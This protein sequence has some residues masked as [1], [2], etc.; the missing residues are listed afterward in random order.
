MKFE[1]R[2]SLFMIV[3]LAALP[4]VIAAQDNRQQLPLPTPIELSEE[5][6]PL[7]PTRQDPLPTL[8]IQP[9]R[10]PTPEVI[11]YPTDDGIHLATPATE[12]LIEYPTDPC[13]LNPTD[14]PG[15]ELEQI[16]CPPTETPTATYV[17]I[18]VTPSASIVNGLWVLDPNG[19]GFRSSGQ[20]QL[21]GGDNGGMGGEYQP[22]DLPKIPVCMTGDR[23]WLKVDA[24]GPYPLVVPSIYS[25][26]EMSREL[27]ESN[28]ET[29]GSVNVNISRQ[30]HVISPSEIEYSYI[31]Q[32]KGGCTTTSTVRYKL[33]EANNLVCSGVVM[34][35]NFTAV[36]TQMPTAKPGETPLP[37]VT[38]VPPIQTGEYTVQLPPVDAS[39]TADQLPQSD[40]VDV[41]YDNNQ[42]MFITFGGG[43][44]TL[45]WNGS[46][47][48]EYHKGQFMVS[49]NTYPGGASLSRIKQGCFM[50][51]QLA[52]EGAPTATPV[53]VEPT[54]EAVTDPAS[55]A[56]S[57]F[58]V[59]WDAP[60]YICAEENKS[61]LPDLST[62]VLTAKADG[63]FTFSVD[64]I[65]YTLTNQDGI[66]GF[67]QMNTDGSMTMINM[68]GF[69][70]GI[71]SGSFSAIGT[72]GKSCTSLLT[73]TP[74][75]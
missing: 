47:D 59:T 2:L 24:S 62:A 21:D 65:D 48:Y 72:G 45:F 19:S 3:V 58:S 39:C 12:E 4:L 27:L 35:P 54:S 74:Q 31:R 61:M 66:Y 56:G 55:I 41:S 18:T 70:E 28:G 29:T 53:P 32:E 71:G 38:P 8:D 40:K 22:D 13:K 75:G 50:N 49:V 33:V 20:C 46:N 30:Y 25:E 43:G 42:N 6:L 5:D 17:P 64:G 44:Y 73:F 51:S 7:L 9:A 16:F 26:S 52:Q 14:N 63:D 11:E 57:S 68:N 23:Q 34:T 37:P 1:H 67:T 10:S 69:Y 36:P 60:A 15:I